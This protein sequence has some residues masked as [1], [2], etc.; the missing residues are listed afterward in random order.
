MTDAMLNDIAIEIFVAMIRQRPDDRHFEREDLGKGYDIFKAAIHGG[1]A[2][3]ALQFAKRISA[4]V[5]V[6]S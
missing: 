2:H 1:G 5:E 4:I 6:A 3:Q